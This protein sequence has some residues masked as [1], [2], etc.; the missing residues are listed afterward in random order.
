M[1]DAELDS[2]NDHLSSPLLIEIY[3]EA[4]QLGA[5]DEAKIEII[6][7]ASMSSSRLPILKL[8]ECLLPKGQYLLLPHR[9]S[10][11]RSTGNDALP[12]PKEDAR[13]VPIASTSIIKTL[14]MKPDNQIG[15]PA[16]TSGQ[17]EDATVDIRVYSYMNIYKG[18]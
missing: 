10:N 6:F 2:S 3:N 13:T 1:A 16:N 17:R 8:K 12:S 9:C 11:L 4:H 7:Q 18:S 15:V 14:I 5:I